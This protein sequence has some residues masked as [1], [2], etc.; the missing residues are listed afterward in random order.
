MKITV[1][2]LTVWQ[3]ILK[4]SSDVAKKKNKIKKSE[5]HN[6]SGFWIKVRG[7]E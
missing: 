7:K 1:I 5:P 6:P 2:S 4:G 3:K